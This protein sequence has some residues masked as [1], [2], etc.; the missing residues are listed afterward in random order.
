MRNWIQNWEPTLD[1]RL[2]A[3]YLTL[4]ST[5]TLHTDCFVKTPPAAGLSWVMS[6]FNRDN[7][8]GLRDVP[9]MC[10]ETFA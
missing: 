6:G 4:N 9:N 10:K 1:A 7:C 8:V 5:S 3:R 2:T